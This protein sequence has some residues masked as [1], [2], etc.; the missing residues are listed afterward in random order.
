[1][2][3]MMKVLIALSTWTLLSVVLGLFVGRAMSFCGRYDA[4]PVLESNQPL[5]NAA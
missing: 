5:R 2:T 4:V 3:L 1:M